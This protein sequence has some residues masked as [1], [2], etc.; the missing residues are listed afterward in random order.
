MFVATVMF[1][2]VSGCEKAPSTP[3]PVTKAPRLEKKA[4]ARWP[5]VAET[6]EE[7]RDAVVLI[8]VPLGD[9]KCEMGTGFLVNDQGWVW[10]AT[11]KL[12]HVV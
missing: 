5:K 1:G 2:V 3:K 8:V 6:L 4:S 11:R 7:A 10:P 9:G 12:I